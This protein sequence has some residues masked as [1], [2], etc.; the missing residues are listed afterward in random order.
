M[1][2]IIALIILV[3]LLIFLLGCSSSVTCKTVTKSVKGCDKIV[4]CTCIHESWGGLGSC[5]TCSC[6]EGPLC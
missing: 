3:C 2:K 1:K 6:K 4:G 5:D